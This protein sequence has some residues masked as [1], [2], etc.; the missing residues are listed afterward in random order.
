M[1]LRVRNENLVWGEQQIL[2]KLQE[3][4][5]AADCREHRACLTLAM[6]LFADPLMLPVPLEID[7]WPEGLYADLREVFAEQR[8][9]LGLACWGNGARSD[10]A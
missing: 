3:M 10:G 5:A 7:L 1:Q 8:S 6:L 2:A 9:E 4:Y